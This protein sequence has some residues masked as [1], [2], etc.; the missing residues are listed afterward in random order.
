[1]S[2]DVNDSVRTMD[3]IED[4]L[5]W[6]PEHTFH[7]RQFPG[8][9]KSWIQK[10][11]L[12]QVEFRVYQRFLTEFLRPLF[13][14]LKSLQH[15]ESLQRK[16][17]NGF[18]RLSS[19]SPSFED[20]FEMRVY[21]DAVFLWHEVHQ[22][23]SKEAMQRQLCQQLM[24]WL[25]QWTNCKG[26]PFVNVM[27]IESIL[28]VISETVSRPE[29][30][31]LATLVAHHCDV[32]LPI[33]F[34]ELRD[35]KRALEDSIES[36][37]PNKKPRT[38]VVNEEKKGDFDPSRFWYYISPEDII[39]LFGRPDADQFKTPI[40]QIAFME[41]YQLFRPKMKEWLLESTQM[42][43]RYPDHPRDDALSAYRG[44]FYEQV[45]EYYDS[46][47]TAHKEKIGDQFD[48][49]WNGPAA[50]ELPEG[51]ILFEGQSSC[52]KDCLYMWG[53]A[54][55]GESEVFQG[56]Y[57]RK[58]PT[59][60][61]WQLNAAL[62]FAKPPNG[63]LFV[64]QIQPGVRAMNMQYVNLLDDDHKQALIDFEFFECEVLLQPGIDIELIRAVTI[65]QMTMK[66]ERGRGEMGTFPVHVIFTQVSPSKDQA[67]P[68]KWRKSQY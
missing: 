55:K 11:P 41:K 10:Y 13:P 51:T 49:I 5:F 24:Y 65:P 53:P 27:T 56:V 25:D 35:R 28:A 4:D 40:N 50:L 9:Y 54:H 60:T 48:A 14:P 64:H 23:H 45:Y 20:F 17:P 37:T 18:H 32:N 42:R 36:D 62:H 34:Q 66:D 26:N 58:R 15:V 33:Y 31:L 43:I 7:E 44:N 16:F 61:S 57:K 21:V 30:Q 47:K 22:S 59:S 12:C 3:S 68:M 39:R 29:P 38:E 46:N 6:S 1:M 67:V 63:V 52:K 19:S 8:I 2:S